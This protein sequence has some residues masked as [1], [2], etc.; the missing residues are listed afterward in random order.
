MNHQEHGQ[1]QKSETLTV[2][3]TENEQDFH[4]HADS[5]QAVSAD[6]GRLRSEF[7]G[8]N[9]E[10]S[11]TGGRDFNP[12]GGI[13]DQLIDDAKK[14]LIKSRECIVW[15]REEEKE[16]QEKVNNL[17]KLK[18]LQEQQYQEMRRQ[19]EMLLQQQPLM[20]QQKT[21]SSNQDGGEEL[22]E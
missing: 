15:Y 3:G 21:D 1:I 20:Q 14:Q 8:L 5:G 13:L 9:R 10:D 17:I 6:S 4:Y 7:V 2:R 19:H 22:A 11:A 18:E 12:F 16:Y